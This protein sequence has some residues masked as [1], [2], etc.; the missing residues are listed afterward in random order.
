ME[1]G[2]WGQVKV[3]LIQAS[4]CRSQMAWLTPSAAF[5]AAVVCGKVSMPSLSS[6]KTGRDSFL[7][8][9]LLSELPLSL[10]VTVGKRLPWLQA[11]VPAGFA[12]PLPICCGGWPGKCT[13]ALG[14]S[15]GVPP[16]AWW[17]WWGMEKLSC[18][19]TLLVLSLKVVK[20]V[21]DALMSKSGLEA[22][23]WGKG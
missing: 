8:Y 10:W 18:L 22:H 3:F 4:F 13:W 15:C 17:G 16:A 6:G 21:L 5:G 14:G 23:C 9:S 20:C 11:G 1:T 12:G 19:L 7:G 2:P